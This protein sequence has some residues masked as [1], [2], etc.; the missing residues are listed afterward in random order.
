MEHKTNE[1]EAKEHHENKE[2][3]G[4]H[5]KTEHK[6][7]HVSHK[8]KGGFKFDSKLAS[9]IVIGALL[10]GIAGSYAYKNLRKDIGEEGAKE[11]VVSY[12]KETLVQDGT[13]VKAKSVVKEY[14]MYKVT[15][16]IQGQEIPTYITKDGKKFFPQAMDTEVKQETA[17]APQQKDIPKSDKPTVDLFVMSYCPFGLQMERG[18]VPVV[19]AFGKKIDFKLKF[20]SYTLHGKKEVDENTRQ[21][22]IQKTQPDKID[23]YL[24]CFWKDSAGKADACMK[25]VGINSSQVSTCT[26]DAAKQFALTEKD[27]GIDKEENK[28]FGVQGSPTLVINGVVSNAG[29]DAKSIQKAI[30]SA[31]NNEPAECAKELSA[32]APAA[33]FDNENAGKA[34]GGAAAPSGAACGQ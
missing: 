18:M 25:S 34:A 16:D 19:Q 24:S 23:E 32:A 11:K 14:G 33:G 27:Y 9:W 7:V 13:E 17:Q 12:I 21:Y 3:S 26:A 20:V 4:E 15:I 1:H 2:N 10:L 5:Q 29:R 30:C 8:K 22:C 6:E 28:K 31:F